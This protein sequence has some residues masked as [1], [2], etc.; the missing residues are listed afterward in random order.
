VGRTDCVSWELA[1]VIE[2]IRT[3]SSLGKE[4]AHVSDMV[5]GADGAAS[6][7]S[8]SALASVSVFGK[9]QLPDVDTE[10]SSNSRA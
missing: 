8:E 4:A 5:R 7:S 6:A 3:L 10:E 1:S 9:V 2:L